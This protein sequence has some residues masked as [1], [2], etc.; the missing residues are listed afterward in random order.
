MSQH[1]AGVKMRETPC[2]GRAEDGN[3]AAPGVEPA[4]AAAKRSGFEM[5]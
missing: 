5:P 1:Y 2:R 4:D 3:A